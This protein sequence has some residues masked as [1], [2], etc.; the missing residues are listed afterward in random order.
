M[1]ISRLIEHA[2][3]YEQYCELAALR[4]AMLDRGEAARP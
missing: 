1:E 2:E 3:T 4:R